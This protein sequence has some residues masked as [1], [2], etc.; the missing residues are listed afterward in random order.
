MLSWAFSH[1]RHRRGIAR[2]RRHCRSRRWHRADPVLH[3]LGTVRGLFAIRLD[4]E[5]ASTQLMLT[6]GI[7]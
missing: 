7:A 3:F 6:V 1:H 5:T 4:A 2:I